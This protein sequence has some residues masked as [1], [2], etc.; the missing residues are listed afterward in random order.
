MVGLEEGR[1]KKLSE[2]QALIAEDTDLQN[3]SEAQKKELI[4]KVTLH[5][6]TSKQGARFNNAAAAADFRGTLK[7]SLEEVRGVS[8][9]S[10][11][12]STHPTEV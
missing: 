9:C 3:S 4:A 2:I 10:P 6:K 12:Y 11:I 5:R 7:K 8:F 1:K